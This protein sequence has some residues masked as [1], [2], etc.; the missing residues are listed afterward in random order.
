MKKLA[1][2]L[3]K[4]AANTSI[5]S[6]SIFSSK[7][8]TFLSGILFLFAVSSNIPLLLYT[9]FTERYEQVS[10]RY[11]L[12]AVISMLLEVLFLTFFYLFVRGFALLCLNLA[13]VAVCDTIFLK[14]QRDEHHLKSDNRNYN[15]GRCLTQIT[16]GNGVI[17]YAGE[18]VTIVDRRS[19]NK[20]WVRKFNGDEYAVNAEYV[21]EDYVIGGY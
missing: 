7:K 1:T 20:L 9:L 16:R 4:T 21:D 3:A 11:R 18:L 6:F 12:A 2:L 19:G 10:V 13:F 15:I 5:T 8:I 17:I 14:K